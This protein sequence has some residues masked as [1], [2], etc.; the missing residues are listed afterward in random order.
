M[1]A[2]AVLQVVCQLSL[3]LKIFLKKK[4]KYMVLNQNY[5]IYEAKHFNFALH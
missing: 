3:D 5:N 2:R 1:G 4:F